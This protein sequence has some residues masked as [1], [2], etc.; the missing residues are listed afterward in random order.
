[1][2]FFKLNPYAF[3][4][5]HVPLGADAAGF[6]STAPLEANLSDIVDFARIN[7]GATRLTVGAATMDLDGRHIM[8]SGA[9]PP[10]VP[11]VRID[12]KLYWDGRLRRHATVDRERSVGGRLRSDRR[13]H[14][15]CGTCRDRSH[16]QLIATSDWR[17]RAFGRP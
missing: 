7:Q 16:Q 17:N 15:A 6:Y 12:G 3:A 10:A 4:G 14:S 5:A 13:V 9:R 2:N 1:M 11:A 8:A